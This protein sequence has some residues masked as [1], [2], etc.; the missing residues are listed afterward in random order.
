MLMRLTVQVKEE[1]KVLQKC[2]NLSGRTDG[3]NEPS[4]NVSCKM[5]GS[6]HN[7]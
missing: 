2:L 3:A 4:M 6:R 5:E 7:A 1:E